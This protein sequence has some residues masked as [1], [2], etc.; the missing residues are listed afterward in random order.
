MTWEAE[1]LRSLSRM[2]SWWQPVAMPTWL[3]SRSKLAASSCLS[4]QLS[5]LTGGPGT[6][7]AIRARQARSR[8]VSCSR[9]IQSAIRPR[10]LPALK[11]CHASSLFDSGVNSTV[12][13]RPKHAARLLC[14]AL[15]ACHHDHLVRDYLS[16]HEG[17]V[18]H[19]A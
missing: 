2:P 5:A 8:S 16:W 17:D 1:P 19:P 7:L 9:R 14:R 3:P 10:R 13:L 4:P 11:P 18:S 6:V 12:S 15:S